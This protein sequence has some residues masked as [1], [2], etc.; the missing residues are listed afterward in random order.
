MS[1]STAL[2]CIKSGAIEKV[3]EAKE[4]KEQKDSSKKDKK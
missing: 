3:S 4:S 1:E 2:A